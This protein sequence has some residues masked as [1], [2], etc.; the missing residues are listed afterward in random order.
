[1]FKMI[2]HFVTSV[3]TSIA[4]RGNKNIAKKIATFDKASYDRQYAKD[5]LVQLRIALHRTTDRDIINKLASLDNKTAYVKA[6]IREDLK[7]EKKAQA[8]QDLQ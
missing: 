3:I 6:L 2:L 7:Q 1:M 8:S 4:E 5:H